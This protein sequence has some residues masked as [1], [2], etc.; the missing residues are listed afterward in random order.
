MTFPSSLI[1]GYKTFRR[2]T[3]GP[4]S[5]DFQKLEHGQSPQTMV[6]ACADSRVDP[7][8]IFNTR[9]GELFIVRNIAALVPPYQP[10]GGLHGVSAALEFAVK[11][12][13]VRNIAV[14]GHGLC[15]G[16]NACLHAS[17]DTPVGEFVAPWVEI[18]AEARR[19]VNE[20]LPQGSEEDRQRLGEYRTIEVSLKNLETFPFIRDRLRDN[21]IALHGIWYSVYKGHLRLRDPET[22]EFNIIDDEE[23]PS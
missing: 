7:G 12:L 19:R 21:E 2:E 17:P 11:V 22:G 15:G 16:V 10:D 13:Q 6:I 23:T 9:P 5:T 8:T 1:D 18:A 14:M 4:L 20:E 3:Y